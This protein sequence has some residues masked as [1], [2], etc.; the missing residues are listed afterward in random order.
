[1]TLHPAVALLHASVEHDPRKVA[2]RTVDSSL[3]AGELGSRV[4]DSALRWT[5]L[6]AVPGDA[7]LVVGA[8]SVEQ[9]IT[10][11]GIW[12]AGLIPVLIDDLPAGR[13][14]RLAREAGARWVADVVTGERRE[15]EVPA[16]RVPSG[17]SHVLFTSGTT[18]EPAGVVVGP[19]A[20]D[21]AL[22]WFV[23]SL[24]P[25]PQ[26]RVPML[27]GLGH[28]PL[29]REILL[30]LLGR[31]ELIVPSE[32]ATRDPRELVG[33]LRDGAIT[34]LNATP[35]LIEFGLG[36]LSQDIALPS[37]RMVLLG[38]EAPTARSLQLL[39]ATGS[40]RILNVYGAT[41]TPQV[42]AAADVDEV[43]GAY[44]R[45]G[46]GVGGY[47]LL[48]GEQTPAWFRELVQ[49]GDDEIVVRA[50]HLA[51][52]Y[53][54]PRGRERFV[55]DPLGEPGWRAYLTGD[56][57]VLSKNGDIAI[58]GRIDREIGLHGHRIHPSEVETAAE[59]IDGVNAAKC[60]LED[61]DLGPVLALRVLPDPEASLNPKAIRAV[62]RQIL[63]GWAV[64][65]R[66]EI[67]A[68]GGVLTTNNKRAW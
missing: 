63:P 61:S 33:V 41:E 50:P 37:L 28:D 59:E 39:R 56:R 32:A 27:G 49:C 22:R 38:G 54:V 16:R 64:P 58:T 51:R 67:E 62:L 36:H 24:A 4:R 30:P 40:A 55:E 66:I 19:E 48:L 11:L 7:I 42:A 34:M 53:L 2:V 8:R 45:V 9:P 57:G 15:R 17:A 25:G 65:S 18:G 14:E 13:Q 60:R 43:G 1:M 68:S 21:A 44:S 20:I 26:D 47:Q 6:G 12:A 29:L 10:L 46:T 31:G 3:T 23:A 5:K 52:G 35:S